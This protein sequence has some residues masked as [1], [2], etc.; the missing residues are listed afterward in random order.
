MASE[1]EHCDV[2]V[3]GGGIAGLC[4]AISARN[5]GASVTLL[6]KGI[7][8]Q[9]GSSPKAAGILAAPF[10]HGDLEQ[11]PW[12]DNAAQYASDV[13]RVGKNINDP[14]LARFVADQ[15]ASSIR[16]LEGLGIKFSKAPDG[17][18]IQLNAPGNSRPRGCS[19]I[20][21][22]SAIMNCLTDE[23]R[24]IGVNVLDSV[25]PRQLLKDCKK[26]SGCLFQDKNDT[27]KIIHSKATILAAGGATGLFRHLSGDQMNTGGGLMLGFDAGAKV[28]NLDFVEFTLIYRVKDKPLRIAG[29]AP[30]MARGALILNCRGDD[31]VEKYFPESAPETVSRADL[32]FAVQNEY[33]NSGGPVML[34]ARHFSKANWHDF[35][36][37]QG[38]AVLDKLKTAGC[39]PKKELVEVLPAAHSILAG[40]VIDRD[41]ATTVTGLFAAGENATGIHGAGRLSGNGLTSCV[42]MGRVAG[43]EA[44]AHSDSEILHTTQY[45]DQNNQET[46]KITK[47]DMN[48]L[49]AIKLKV[50]EAAE[51]GLGVIRNEKDIELAIE[52]FAAMKKKIEAFNL[53]N[54][55]TFEIWQMTRLASMMA[56]A[57]L[58]KQ[59]RHNGH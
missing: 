35:E 56:A 16:W 53:E 21:G 18:F 24:R 41:A 57:A 17:G 46:T 34:D 29:L 3:I 44:A 50:R 6:N 26:V 59:R 1:K 12:E 58:E 38:A 19:A 42:V 45:V 43:K 23:V 13:L 5:S 49:E 28:S 37:G 48:R 8:G 52:T 39:D 55:T 47:K 14:S 11:R 20:G 36:I 27:T 7:T 25:K 2:L 4:S 15:A 32:L 30:F 54:P 10:G 9:S 22:G 40:L 31:L 51:S 33:Q